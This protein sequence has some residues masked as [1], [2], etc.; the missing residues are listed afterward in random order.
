LGITNVYL[1]YHIFF[2]FVLN[3]LPRSY[4][5]VQQAGLVPPL[6]SDWMHGMRSLKYGI[7]HHAQWCKEECRSHLV[8]YTMGWSIDYVAALSISSFF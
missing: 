4:I 7:K 5:A 8:S 6:S 1:N 3:E 2:P